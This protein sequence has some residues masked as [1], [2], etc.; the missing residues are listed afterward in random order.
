M[1]ATVTII[2][3]GLVTAVGWN[4]AA[5]CAA[6]RGKVKNPVQT[7]YAQ[8]SGE[9]I[10]AYRIPSVTCAGLRHALVEWASS[11]VVEAL[12]VLPESAQ[13][14]RIPL[15]LCLAENDRAWRPY[16]HG[17]ELLRDISAATCLSFHPASAVIERGRVSV[18]VALATA[19]DLLRSKSVD[20]VLVAGVDSLVSS[21]M[22]AH[23]DSR[24]RLLAKRNANGFIAGEAAGALLVATADTMAGGMTL[25]GVGFGVETATIETGGALRAD[26]LTTAIRNALDQAG[27]QM[28][29][30]GFRLGDLSGEQYYFKEAALAL[31]R[32]LR[33]RRAQFDL[34]HPAECVGEVGAAAGAVAVAVAKAAFDKSYALGSSALIHLAN[35]SGERSAIVLEAPR[36]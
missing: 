3:T 14:A 17:D 29:D 2:G 15:L 34:W 6:I 23:F 27:C 13:L 22:L 1:S 4:A 20:A 10:T 30:I 31:A 18:G 32:T 9:W 33:R 12:D 11:A 7:A 25:S 5:S 36:R 19:Q 35:D 8:A 16:R 21:S 24:G 26:G 28:H